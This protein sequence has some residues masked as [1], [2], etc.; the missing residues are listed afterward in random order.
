VVYL[1]RHAHAGK[2]AAWRGPDLTRPLSAAGRGQAAGLVEQLAGQ[3]VRR[4]LSSPAVR[5]LQTVRPLAG[6]LGLAIE[7]DDRLGVD[8]ATGDVLELLAAP[9]LRQAV[10]CTHGEVIGRVF[11]ELQGAGLAMPAKPRWP[12][13][14]TWVLERDGSRAWSGRFL[15]PKT[16]PSPMTEALNWPSGGEEVA[17]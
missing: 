12:K 4:I 17:G 14:S 6:R 15:A 9:A 10:V 16:V 13:G 11:A 8:G 1:V 7:P 2:K 3:P 5:C